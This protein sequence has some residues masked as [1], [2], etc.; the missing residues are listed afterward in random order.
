MYKAVLSH[1]IV[2]TA[3]SILF[4]RIS[5]RKTVSRF[6][7]ENDAFG[8]GH[9]YIWFAPTLRL[10]AAPHSC[11]SGDLHR[12][13]RCTGAFLS[14][15]NR[16]KCSGCLTQ[17]LAPKPVPT[18]GGH[19]LAANCHDQILSLSMNWNSPL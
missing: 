11:L 9:A 15:R 16:R 2:Q 5:E 17:V 12:A 3:L 1:G 8:A 4:P 6:R 18:F 13:A 10:F 14:E 7:S 19:A